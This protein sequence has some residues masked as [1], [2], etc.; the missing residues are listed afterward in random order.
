MNSEE[1]GNFKFADLSLSSINETDDDEFDLKK[2]IE[3]ALAGLQLNSVNN[4][5][6][7]ILEPEIDSNIELK[8][9]VLF[10]D[11]DEV[12]L[13]ESEDIVTR[14]L[15]DLLRRAEQRLKRNMS[16]NQKVI[17]NFKTFLV[18]KYFGSVKKSAQ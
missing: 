13:N 2:H 16:I 8:D 17:Q 4:P 10:N 15:E 3:S 14:Q 18:E 11:I 1:D 9:P 7:N 5:H 12:E 6:E